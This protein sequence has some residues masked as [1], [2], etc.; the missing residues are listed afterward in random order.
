M[1]KKDFE[2]SR[3]SFGVGTAGIATI[4]QDLNLNYSGDS[5]D[6]L[7]P[8]IVNNIG[9]LGFNPSDLVLNNNSPSIFQFIVEIDEDENVE[10]LD[11]WVRENDDRE[12]NGSIN[13][14][15][16]VVSAPFDN[17][18]ATRWE[19]ESDTLA[20]LSYVESI[21]YNIQYQTMDIDT[22]LSSS[23][24]VE[25]PMSNIST[26]V[27]GGTFSSEGL[28]FD[29][30]S[31]TETLGKAVEY[32]KKDAESTGEGITVSVLDTGCN[33]TTDN[34][35]F[36][37]RIVQSKNFITDEVGIDSVKDENLHGTW[38]TAA[39]GANPDDKD[40]VGVATECDLMV[41][42]V[43]D[44]D[45]GG[46]T[47]DIIRGIEWS[48]EN[49]ADVISMS[50]GSPLYNEQIENAVIDAVESGVVVVIAAGNSRMTVRWVASPADVTD[51]P[52]ITVGA[53]NNKEPEDMNSVY[54]SQ[55][56]PDSGFTD[57]SG[58]ETRGASIDIGCSGMFIEAKVP[59]SDGS[60]GFSE[61]SGTSMATPQIAGVVACMMSE[62]ESLVG[63]P[64]EVK[65]KLTT[66]TRPS[67]ECGVTEVGDGIAALDLVLEEQRHEET[68]RGF[69]SDD[70]IGRD[71]ANNVYSGSLMERYFFDMD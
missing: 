66:Y 9:R 22:V 70:A 47:D 8:A 71:I 16:H 49:G 61:L 24:W 48:V 35:I 30:N 68:Q 45:G 3:R 67:K 60:T 46:S 33:V 39:V 69:R 52:T 6:V 14:N 37:N 42:R 40:Y 4:Q 64:D 12:L 2:M 20:S 26:L 56:G 38:C 13:D 7:S 27:G 23:D 21:D 10:T 19:S 18:L 57:N 34:S 44:D 32:V 51:V 41:G 43:M 54:F 65:N 53:T 59:L 58:G 28:A 55:V 17:I 31:D 62:N 63:N 11:N 25:P 50:L 1:T 15:L 5:M 29:E 36:Q